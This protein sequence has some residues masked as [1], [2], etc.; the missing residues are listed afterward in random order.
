MRQLLKN[1]G[2]VSAAG[3]D[4]TGPKGTGGECMSG[5]G[6]ESNVLTEDLIVASSATRLRYRVK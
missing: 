2:F 1:R 4:G 6:G 5:G 3:W